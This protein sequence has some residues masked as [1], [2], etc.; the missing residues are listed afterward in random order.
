[1]DKFFIKLKS[2]LYTTLTMG[3]LLLVVPGFLSGSLGGTVVVIGIMLLITMIGNMVIA[4]P[5]SYL[6]DLLTRR[7][8]SFR[9]PAAGLIH[10]AVGILPVI[11]LDEIAIYTIADALIYFLFTEWQQSKGSFKWSARAAISGASVAAIVAAAFVSI[12][13][14][15]A[16]FQDRTHDAYLIPK[17]FEGEMKIVH[18]IDRAPKQK[19]K[20]GYDIV[21][22]DEAGYGITSKPLTTALIEDKYYYV[23]KKGKKEEINKD[24]I[25]VGGRN[26]I[27]GDDYQYNYEA[28]Y[29]T[30]KMCGKVFKQNGQKYFG[31]KLQIEEIL[32]KEG[33]AKMTDYG[34]TILPQK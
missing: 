32:F 15:V 29:V 5:V 30:S 8:G 23:D 21:K 25:S 4:I 17:G 13:T 14:L 18:G 28:L 9:F 24:C 2:A 16:I 12:P 34:Y 26:A 10:I 27:A 7:L 1:M 3:V 20:D 6:A 22:V 31:E 19:T 33:L 11:L